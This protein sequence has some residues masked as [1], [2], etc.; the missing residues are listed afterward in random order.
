[1]RQQFLIALVV[2][3]ISASAG[4]DWLCGTWSVEGEA[5]LLRPSL[6]RPYTAIV[7]PVNNSHSGTETPLDGRWVGNTRPGYKWG[8]RAGV[9]Y[10]RNCFDV[11]GRY[12]SWIHTDT[13]NL[14]VGT[15]ERIWMTSTLDFSN[16]SFL[17]P[18]VLDRSDQLKA[19]SIDLEV[20]RRTQDSH[21]WSARFFA[22]V[23]YSRIRY[24]TAM[25][26]AGSDIGSDF[27][28]IV[29][30]NESDIQGIG[31]RIGLGTG[32]DLCWGFRLLGEASAALL[33]GSKKGAYME[34]QNDLAPS[35]A[36]LFVSSRIDPT[37]VVIANAE[38][39][40]GFGYSQCLGY[41]GGIEAEV[42]YRI[43][44]FSEGTIRAQFFSQQN[45]GIS[46]VTTQPF[47]LDGF[48]FK[49]GAKY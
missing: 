4:A 17:S 20:G 16:L 13:F 9:G 22:G 33:F 18:G 39:F 14:A 15:D 12:A 35:P 42:G 21:C 2:L 29:L 30:K 6:D 28:L 10:E 19:Q 26:A 41:S 49:L 46:S 44:Y 1:M 8:F 23:R 48:V 24:K 37:D 45:L 34:V 31:P 5:L 11:R 27:M 38:G 43:S 25:D 3:G 36:S 40:F 7:A 47:A 32:L